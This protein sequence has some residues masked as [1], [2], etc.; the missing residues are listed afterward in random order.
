MAEFDYI[1]IGAGS[2]GCVLANRLSED[3]G[4]SVLVLEAGGPDR[5]PF[6]AMPL[7]MRKIWPDPRYN[8][9]YHTEPEPGLDGRSIFLPRGRVLGGSSSINAMVYA[10]GHPLDYDQWRQMGLTGWGFGDVLPYFKRAESNWRGETSHHG[11]DGPLGVSAPQTQS[12]LYHHLVQSGIAAGFPASGDLAG[13]EPEGI[14]PTDFTIKNGRRASTARVYLHPALAR[15]NLKAETNA[16]VHKIIVENG[17]AQGVRYA[18]G[19]QI[20]NATARREVILSAGAYNSPQIL[21][22]SGI[23]PG[24]ELAELGIETVLDAPNVGRNLHDHLS[25]HTTYECNQPISFDP[26]LRADRV[27]LSV[28][29]WFLTH[30]GTAA[31]LPM[32]GSAFIRTREGLEVPDI[33][34]LMSPVALDAHMWFPFIKKPRGHRFTFRIVMLHPESRGQ[35]TL[36][37]AAPQDHPRIQFNFLTEEADRATC[38]AGIRAVRKIV[39]AEPL[40]G[41]AEQELKPGPACQSDD[42]IDAYIRE[43]V[44]VDHH[45]VGTC[46]MGIDDTSVVDGD[47][48]VRGLQGLRVADASIMPTV[49]GANTNATAIMIGEKASDLIRGRAAPPALEY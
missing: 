30:K 45:P 29:R 46:R 21:L 9:G 28:A 15:P 14:G 11:A 25:F 27:A 47:L 17:R 16:L 18:K 44:E 38:R 40:A 42:E 32:T 8:W 26:L 12:P 20:H 36:K 6:L 1:I 41:L 35:L 49:T 43:S 33:E 10:R 22:L 3:A 13:A 24:A 2:A 34:F 5:N 48:R 37:S 7:A 31:S 39:G 23:G 19:G 4:T